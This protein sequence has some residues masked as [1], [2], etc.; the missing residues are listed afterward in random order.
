[1][2]WRAPRG[3]FQPGQR[4]VHVR[5]AEGR[6]RGAHV[7]HQHTHP[8]QGGGNHGQSLESPPDT[9]VQN[10]LNDYLASGAVPDKPGLVNATC[11]PTAD[12]TP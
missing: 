10:Y 5:Q 7:A 2:S 8:T 12:P 6:R 9:C 3:A 11:A 1:M 4:P